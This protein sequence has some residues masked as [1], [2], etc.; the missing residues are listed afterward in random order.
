[1][2]YEEAKKTS[3][4]LEGSIKCT[5]VRFY[6]DFG[7]KGNPK[8]IRHLFSLQK[9]QVRG[10]IVEVQQD[11]AQEIPFGR[12]V[13]RTLVRVAVKDSVIEAISTWMK[14]NPNKDFSYLTN[15]LNDGNLYVCT[16][17]V[18]WFKKVNVLRLIAAAAA[19][20]LLL[21]K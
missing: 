15:R 8:D 17:A 21:K 20:V 11:F 7:G 10:A 5:Y 6:Y 2:T 1:M 19:V 16:N 3:Q 14:N 18:R 4:N 13:P 12:N 9:E